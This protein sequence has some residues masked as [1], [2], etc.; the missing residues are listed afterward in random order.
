MP[1]PRRPRR[2]AVSPAVLVSAEEEKQTFLG[3]EDAL[4]ISVAPPPPP[5]R[6]P[7]FS[8]P[9]APPRPGHTEA[10]EAWD[11]WAEADA[12][13]IGWLPSP[14]PLPPLMEDWLWPQGPFIDLTLD[15]DD[16]DDLP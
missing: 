16:D 15:E 3:L 11:L 8:P 9:G 5:R 6:Q 7:P 12:P 14:P 10:T 1:T 4:F 13:T 2:A